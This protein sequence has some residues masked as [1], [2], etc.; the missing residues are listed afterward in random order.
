MEVRSALYT[1]ANAMLTRCTGVSSIK[2]WGMRLM[3]T[4]GRCRAVVAVTRKLAFVMHRMW[5]D[6][7]SFC[8]NGLEVAT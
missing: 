3:Q 5:V 2:S 8:R 1:V 7:T 6:D 4:K